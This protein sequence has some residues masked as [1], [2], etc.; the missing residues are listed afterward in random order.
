MST[1]RSSG[2]ATPETVG[3]SAPEEVRGPMD[4]TAYI[5][6]IAAIVATFVPPGLFA[7]PVLGLL[8]VVLGAAASVQ[9]S[10]AGRPYDQALTGLVLGATALLISGTGLWLF[11]HVIARAIHD[12]VTAS[13][14]W[15]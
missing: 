8:A 13:V 3:A 12:A 15:F 9:A 5:L 7:A 1:V 11:R 4:R 10:R 6:G 2:G 14:G